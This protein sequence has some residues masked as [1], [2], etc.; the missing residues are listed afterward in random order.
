VA[1]GGP[2]V[3]EYLLQKGCT[4][5]L[6]KTTFLWTDAADSRPLAKS[7]YR[8]RKHV[9][10]I[11]LAY[12]ADPSQPHFDE[13]GKELS[14]LWQCGFAGHGSGS[15]AQKLLAR[16]VLV[17]GTVQGFETPFATAVRNRCFELAKFLLENNANPHIEYSEGL[18]LESAEPYTVLGFLIREQTRSALAAINWMLCEVPEMNFIVSSKKNYSVLHIC[19]VAKKWTRNEADEGACKLISD[20]LISHFKPTKADIDL[21]DADGQTALYCA[22]LMNNFQMV[23]IL[24][25]AGADPRIRNND[26]LSAINANATLL[27]ILKDNPKM[28]VGETDPRPFAKQTERRMK[29]QNI[30]HQYFA[31]FEDAEQT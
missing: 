23:K 9:F 2:E 21:R 11:L 6:N 12:G 8:A 17:D 26:D 14:Y 24:L 15:F 4:A 22:T 5:D 29:N 18:Y 1:L 13:D 28:F 3:V 27:Q 30:I 7:I 19:A 10:D 16:G 20:V 25:D 31:R